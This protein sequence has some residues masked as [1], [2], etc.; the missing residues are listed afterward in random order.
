M[1]CR[2]KATTTTTTRVALSMDLLAR[3]VLY[4]SIT[5]FAGDNIEYTWGL[6]VFT[7]ISISSTIFVN[8]KWH[9]GDL[10]K[11]PCSDCNRS[12][13]CWMRAK[14]DERQ[15][16]ETSLESKTTNP[17]C[18]PLW[19]FWHDSLLLKGIY[20]FFSHIRGNC[21]KRLCCKSPCAHIKHTNFRPISSWDNQPQHHVQH[22]SN[23]CTLALNHIP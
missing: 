23:K 5:H 20:T 19:T 15:H 13:I 8:S 10:L 9:L 2:W 11:C 22:V 12:S 14:W 4:S 18:I 7:Y 21:V 1:I 3:R 16:T 17:N 6:Y